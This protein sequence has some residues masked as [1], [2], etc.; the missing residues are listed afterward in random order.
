MTTAPWIIAAAL[1]ARAATAS[2]GLFPPAK[3]QRAKADMAAIS[4]AL[5]MY[6]IN[7]GEYPSTA[8]GLAALAAK[9][10]AAPVPRRWVRLVDKVPTDPWGRAYHYA[11]KDGK[12]E[13][14]SSGPDANTK[15]DDIRHE[16]PKG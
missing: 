11:L 4:T 8:Q 14:W 6:K 10:E 2:A 5:Q 12:V 7:S 15:D 16:E 1:L 13:L 3:S 9:P